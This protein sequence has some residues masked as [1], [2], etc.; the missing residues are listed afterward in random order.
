MYKPDQRR[1]RYLIAHLMEKYHEDISVINTRWET[2]IDPETEAI[3]A[4][5]PHYDILMK[6]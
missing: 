2:F 3:L 5:L 6:G 1:Q 4:I